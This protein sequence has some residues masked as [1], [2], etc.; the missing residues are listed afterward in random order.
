MSTTNDT[1]EPPFTPG[2]WHV[3][4]RQSIRGPHGEYI[5]RANWK[6][7]PA[8]ALA[9]AAAPAL[10]HALSRIV[11]GDNGEGAYQQAV[12]ALAMAEGKA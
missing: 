5:A 11:S 12:E 2:P 10:Y 9:L 6:N 7:G 1:L 3:N 4:G 8:N